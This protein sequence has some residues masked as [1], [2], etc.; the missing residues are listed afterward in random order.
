LS[1]P[2]AFSTLVLQ[3]Q[4]R[5]NI[6]SEPGPVSTAEVRDYLNEGLTAFH[7]L[8]VGARGQEH[9]RKSQTFNTVAGTA[10]YP[11]ASDFYELISIDIQL[12]PNQLLNAEPYME[13]ERNAFKLYPAWAGWFLSMPV[14]YRIQGTASDQNVS[15]VTEKTLNFIPTPQ[16][17]YPITVNYVWRYP[18]FDTAGSQDTNLVNGVNGWE[19]YAV[20]YA[21][22]AIKNRLREDA[23]F[24]MSKMAELKARIESLAPQNDAG[25]A[26]R[27]RDVEV[28]WD[29]TGRWW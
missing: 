23:S 5:A 21:V 7:D 3:A 16:A 20:W 22:A 13:S 1:A 18:T 2:V 8:L 10:A 9:C 25:R 11:L 26:E 6:D 12:A 4:R 14:F 17:A 15:A 28:D 19:L 29:S 24:A 27:I